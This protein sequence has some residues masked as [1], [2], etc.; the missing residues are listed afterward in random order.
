MLP[1]AM[2]VDSQPSC[3]SS[4]LPDQQLSGGSFDLQAGLA[5]LNTE[6]L[7][8]IFGKTAVSAGLVQSD[9]PCAWTAGH[10]INASQTLDMLYTALLTL[11]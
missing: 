6:R 11:P 1:A 8:S 3:I 5:D 10:C 7:S 2:L 4:S 9:A